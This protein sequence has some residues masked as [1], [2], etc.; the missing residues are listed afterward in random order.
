MD[1]GE[2]VRPEPP[3]RYRRAG[4][5]VGPGTAEEFSRRSGYARRSEDR[6]GGY[7]KI[8]SP[9]WS[10]PIKRS[11]SIPE[12]ESWVKKCSPRP[13]RALLVNKGIPDDFMAAITWN[14]RTRICGTR[15]G[16]GAAGLAPCVS[17]AHAEKIGVQ[18]GERRS[19][20]RR[21]ARPRWNRGHGQLARGQVVI[22]TGSDWYTWKRYMG[23]CKPTDFGQ[24][25]GSPGGN[26]RCT[27]YSLPGSQG[28]IGLRRFFGGP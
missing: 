16:R 3:E 13:R 2:S 9:V 8:I 25:P 14:G 11:M 22:P 10:T 1:P 18:D 28:S 4:Y 26:A 21:L 20:R 5:R 23:K 15:P 7:G 24:R 27:V 6:R 17:T 12:M 19:W